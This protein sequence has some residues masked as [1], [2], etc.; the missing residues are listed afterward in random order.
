MSPSG[1][2]GMRLADLHRGQQEGRTRSTDGGPL[3][4]QKLTSNPE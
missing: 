2:P 4:I 1:L 3:S